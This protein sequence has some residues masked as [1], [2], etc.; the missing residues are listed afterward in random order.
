MGVTI[1]QWESIEQWSPAV[2]LVAGGFWFVAIALSISETF[3]AMSLEAPASVAGFAGAVLSFV[4][5]LGLYPQLADQIPRPV[6]VG[7]VLVM[8][9]LIFTFVLLVWHIPELFGIAWPSL[10]VFLPSPALAY[11]ATFALSAVGIA[12]FALVSLRTDAH[13]RPVGS[14]LLVLAAAWVVLIGGAMRYGFPIPDWVTTIQ[15]GMMAMA[16]LA[17][18]YLLRTETEPTDRRDVAQAEVHHD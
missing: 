10:L 16:L 2:F 5:F 8:L 9:L 18:G 3:V 6:Q 13:S 12:I 7:I 15:G 1:L 11:G 14:L 4:G 17:I